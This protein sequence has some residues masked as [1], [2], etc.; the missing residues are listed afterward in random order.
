MEKQLPHDASA[1][2][3][4]KADATAL[5]LAML[6]NSPDCVKLLNIEG[7]ISFMSENGMCAMEIDNPDQIAGK[8][9]W[10][11]WP[12]ESRGNLQASFER[13]RDGEE[14]TFAGACPTAKGDLRDWQVSI[15]PVVEM[16]GKI[17]SILAV[18]RDVTQRG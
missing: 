3:A 9:W 8:T 18:S 16:D 15:T 5:T 14:V 10:D 7:R 1:V 11:L 6:R 17:T 12:Q 2:V 4:A 13:A